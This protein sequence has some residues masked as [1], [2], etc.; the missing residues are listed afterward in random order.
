MSPMNR[1][2]TKVLAGTAVLAVGVLASAMPAT[3]AGT[4]AEVRV[5]NT[6]TV[7]VYLSP[8]GE[9]ETK[10][11]YEQLSLTGS[12]DVQLSN[13]VAPD[14]VRNLDG[15]GGWD[16]EDGVQT[17]ETT[18][19]GEQ[20]LR[21]VSDFQGDLPLSISVDY[22]LDGKSVQ[23]GDVVGESGRLDVTYTVENTTSAPQEVSYDDGNGG[24]VTKTVDVAIPVVGSLTTVAPPNFKNVSSDQAN[25]AGDGQGGTKLS[26]TMTLFPPIGSTTAT[27]GYSAD[28]TE[29][30]VPRADISALPVNPLN[31]P[32]FASAAESYQGGADTGIELTEGATT[33]D[34]NLLQLRDGAADLLSGLIQLNDGADQLRAGLVD[35]AAPGAGRL[36]DGAGDLQDGLGRLD[37][38]ARQLA[39]GTGDLSA[40]AARLGAGT[41]S[42]LEG[43]KDLSAG[44]SQISEGLGQLA[45]AQSGLPAAAAGIQALK[46]GVDTILIKVGTTTQADTLV[47]GLAALDTGLGTAKD[48]SAQVRDGIASLAAGLPVAKGGVDQV[49]AGLQGGSG[50]TTA[51]LTGIGQKVGAALQT[52]GCQAEPV[53]A[54][55]LS[56]ALAALTSLGGTLSTSL[57]QAV[58]GLTA[59]S[60]G[61][62]S[63]IDGVSLLA[64]GSE[65]LATGVAEAEAGA[66]KLLAGSQ[67]LKAGLGEVRQG[68]VD[69][70]EGVQSAVGGIRALDS[71]ALDAAAGGRELSSGLGQLDAG[72][73]DLVAGARQLDD[74]A[75][76]LAQG[77][78]DAAAGS[79]QLAS[80]A[81]ELAN[82]LRGAADG[83]GRL[84]EGLE[85]AADGAPALVDGAQ[86]L[87]DE[88]TKKLVAA[89]KATSQDYGELVAVMNAGAERAD[90]EEMVFGAPDGAVGLAAYSFVVE[91]EDGEGGR[92][93]VRGLG[94]LV[95]LGTGAGVLAARRRF[96]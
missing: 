9:V 76:Q 78:G 16:V 19:D 14:G 53:C 55:Q 50:S 88:G 18:V 24:T 82:G 46:A 2:P 85:Q 44:L 26:F 94:G 70:A 57:G 47:G 91:G 51:A 3:A 21:S 96:V 65:K 7:Q 48:G 56:E 11:I 22:Q 32:T 17:L 30:V 69:L 61:L 31:V 74:G 45:D 95:V 66:G 1:F 81:D 42:A 75:G 39:G 25:L 33:I 77:A 93:L 37:D 23:P 35:Q 29:G 80:G 36:A 89:G 64:P 12:G 86:R 60:G 92:N 49:L 54:T 72:A 40:G 62:K 43:S 67:E 28:I 52:A 15:F 83:S 71:G 8:T 27:F 6:E 63:A 5:V 84:A 10:R 68:L 73:G 4:D 38:G 13:P 90:A 79:Q 87:S 34:G 59:V 58:A 41:G 20:E